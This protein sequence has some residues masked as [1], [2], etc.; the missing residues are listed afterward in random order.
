M[1]LNLNVISVISIMSLT[2][3]IIVLYG[4]YRCI[5]PYFIDP[6]TK[7]ICIDDVCFDGWHVSHF[8][9]Y[10]LLTAMFPK[11]FYIWFT[12]GLIWEMLEFYSENTYI[13]ILHCKDSSAN[14]MLKWWGGRFS[15]IVVNTFGILVAYILVQ[16]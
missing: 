8:I 3:L 6:L 2:V 5:D 15:D 9:F 7:K 1:K 12:A 11:Y 16:K 13:H 14:A 10:F 4:R